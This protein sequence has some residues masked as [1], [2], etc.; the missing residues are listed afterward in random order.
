MKRRAFIA[1]L[2]GVV[3]CPLSGWAQG[4][5]RRP[6]VAIQSGIARSATV[7]AFEQGLRELEFVDG[8][9][10]ELQWRYI[11]GDL[12]RI[13]SVISELVSLKPDAIVT[14]AT[15]STLAARRVAPSGPNLT[16]RFA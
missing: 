4:S 16:F 11:D 7:A 9:N 12:T 1:A 13:T 3:A 6:L 8:Q 2:G 14:A 15:S 5:S 10:V